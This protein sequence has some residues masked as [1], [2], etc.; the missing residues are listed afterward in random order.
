MWPS[1]TLQ[2]Q[3]EVMPHFTFLTCLRMSF[4]RLLA[5]YS[6]KNEVVLRISY[7][8]TENK[9]F[10][11]TQK[12]FSFYQEASYGH[13]FRQCSPRPQLTQSHAYPEEL[14]SLLRPYAGSS[15]W[16]TALVQQ[17]STR[18]LSPPF[19]AQTCPPTKWEKKNKASQYIGGCILEITKLCSDF[20]LCI[21]ALTWGS[22]VENGNWILQEKA[23]KHQA[24]SGWQK[25]KTF[26]SLGWKED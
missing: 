16:E 12:Q 22:K 26:L 7:Y 25:S 4:I 20:T 21:Q 8:K 9:A 11:W 19:W 3:P 23:G 2:T 17:V 13:S 18:M 14:G 1:M 15:G 6:T 5:K 10:P 24:F